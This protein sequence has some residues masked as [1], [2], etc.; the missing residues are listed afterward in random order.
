[1]VGTPINAFCLSML[2][3]GWKEQEELQLKNQRQVLRRLSTENLLGQT[4][5]SAGTIKLQI[6]SN[7]LPNIN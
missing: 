2:F 1:M 7:E 3:Y 4:K 5:S 6:T